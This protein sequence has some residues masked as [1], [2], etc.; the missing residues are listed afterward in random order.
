[1]SNHLEPEFRQLRLLLALKRHEQPPP[2]YFD[3]L[4]SQVQNALRAAEV[5]QVSREPN[6]WVRRLQLRLETLQARPAFAVGLGA[7]FC[8]LLIGSV[9]WSENP[10]P[11]APPVRS[12]LTEVDR[13]PMSP[14]ESAAPLTLEPNTL[15]ASNSATAG[16]PTLF[17]LIQPPTVDRAGINP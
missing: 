15:L 10:G 8:V 12:L 14:V 2:G 6:G 9:V 13:Q 17:D 7:A 1:M 5:Q 3:F 16:N 11:T 4:P